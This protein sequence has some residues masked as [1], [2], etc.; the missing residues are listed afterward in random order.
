MQANVPS[1]IYILLLLFTLV[2]LYWNELVSLYW[3]ESTFWHLH[4]CTCYIALLMEFG[5]IVRYFSSFAPPL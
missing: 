1:V 2:S 5:L 4:T 3:N